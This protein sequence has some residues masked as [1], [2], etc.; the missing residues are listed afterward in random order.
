MKVYNVVTE[1]MLEEDARYVKALACGHSE[2]PER[3]EVGLCS[4]CANDAVERAQERQIDKE[5]DDT[6]HSEDEP[7]VEPTVEERQA[8]FQRWKSNCCWT[9]RL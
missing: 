8:D 6:G 7:A 5:Q 1:A 4:D 3:I 9:A 2:L